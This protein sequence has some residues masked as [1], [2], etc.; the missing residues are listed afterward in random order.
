M[1]SAK[2]TALWRCPR[3]PG[4]VSRWPLSKERASG[5]GRAFRVVHAP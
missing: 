3:L 4:Y 5:A 1:T 2:P